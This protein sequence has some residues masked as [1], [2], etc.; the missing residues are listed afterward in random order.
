MSKNFSADIVKNLNIDKDG[1][2]HK[3]LDI[4][5]NGVQLTF[6]NLI[7]NDYKLYELQDDKLI[8]KLVD[9]HSKYF[10][11]LSA[12]ASK[13]NIKYNKENDTMEFI[14]DI[15]DISYDYIG[16]CA[17]PLPLTITNETVLECKNK[18]DNDNIIKIHEDIIAMAIYTYNKYQV[19][20]LYRDINLYNK[21]TIYSDKWERRVFRDILQWMSMQQIECSEEVYENRFGRTSDYDLTYHW[22]VYNSTLKKS[23]KF[24]RFIPYVYR[25]CLVDILEKSFNMTTN[26]GTFICNMYQKI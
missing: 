5:Q 25:G 15:V 6:Y 4:P 2:F 7:I 3:L 16:Q 13:I 12:R 9:N 14:G 24:D 23:T 20:Y 18:A 21:H 10:Y 1:V 26:S 22:N 11:D 19:K 8:N 17:K